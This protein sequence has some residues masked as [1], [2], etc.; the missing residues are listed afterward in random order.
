MTDF[1]SALA[2]ARSIRA[3]QVSC[4]EVMTAY[5]ARI[6]RFNPG[7]NAI[8][9]LRD[10]GELLREADERDR[11]LARGEYRGP[12]HGFPHA[13]KDVAPTRGMRTTFGSPLFREFVP[14]S[15]AIFVERLRKSGAILIG[16]TN[17][18]EFGLGSHTYNPVFGITRNPYDP[19]KSAG[20]SS[21][22]AAA[23]LAL[24]MLPVADG[25]DMMGSLRNPAAFNNIVGFRPSYGRVPATNP[26]MFVQLLAFEGPMGRSVADVAMLL[27]VQAGYDERVPLSIAQDPA[28]FAEPLKRDV[29]GMRLAWLGD[30]GG[31]LPIERGIPELCRDALKVFENLGCIVEEA[32]PAFSLPQLWETWITLRHWLVA[33]TYSPLYD[34]PLKRAQ[35]KPEMQWEIEGGRR[36]SALDVFNASVARA[37]WYEAV[38]KL[39]ESYDFLLLPGAQVFPWQ[40]EIHWPREIAGVA[41][42]TYHRWMEVYIPGTLAGCPVASV[43]IGFGGN[44]L[45]MGMQIIGRNHADRA[46]L[47]LA[48]AYEQATQWTSKVLPPMLGEG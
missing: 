48:H 20:G 38:R 1:E 19:R 42:D 47:E 21:G 2:L 11:E 24:R 32:L 30:L 43:P 13:V 45:P 14:A 9:S 37:A 10:Q 25:S 40:A 26:G 35:M 44:G 41:M 29:R 23:A 31:H 3:K 46:V 16:K 34:D 17:V 7:V 5:L 4:R 18:P 36:L 12:L 8:I 33:G 39:L 22:G 28:L 27:S 6:E 15:D